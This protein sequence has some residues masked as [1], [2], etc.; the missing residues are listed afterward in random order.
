MLRDARI[1]IAAFLM[2]Y[3]PACGG[4][5]IPPNSTLGTRTAGGA[6]SSSRDQSPVEATTPV[7]ACGWPAALN[8]TDARAGQCVAYRAYLSCK[9]SNGGENCLST[10][11]ARCLNNAYNAYSLIDAGSACTDLCSM[12]EYAVACGGPG[13]GPWPGPPAGCRVLPSGPGGGSVSC[14][15][16]SVP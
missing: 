14:C 13:P 16:C 4:D 8:G 3:G 11:P 12:Q 10:D 7:V 2:T 15:P 6:A 5:V 9:E 1:V